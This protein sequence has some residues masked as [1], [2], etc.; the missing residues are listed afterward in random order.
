MRMGAVGALVGAGFTL[1]LPAPRASAAAANWVLLSEATPPPVSGSNLTYDPVT[2]DVVY[3]G[4][5]GGSDGE[6]WLFNGSSWSQQTTAA[7]PP[8]LYEPSIAYDA[9]T[10]YVVLYGGYNGA[11]NDDQTWL[12]DGTNWTL[13]N[14]PAGPPPLAGASLAYDPSLGELVMYGGGNDDYSPTSETW[15]YNGTTW[16]EQFPVTSPPPADDCGFAY[17]P[18][19]GQM[20]LFG[21]G[22]TIT[23]SYTTWTYDGTN[24]TELS[25]ATTPN[26]PRTNAVFTWDPALNEFILFGGYTLVNSDDVSIGDTWAFDGNNWT[27]LSPAT[28]PPSRY[29]SALVYDPLLG[30]LV[31]FGG[32]NL[33]NGNLSNLNDTWTYGAPD[34]QSI[35]FTSTEPSD[36]TIATSPYTPTATASSSLPVTI[37]LDPSST[38]CSLSSGVVTFNSVGTCVLDANQSGDL[39]WSAAVQVQQTIVIHQESQTIDFSTTPP[40]A[41]VTGGTPYTP[42]ATASSGLPVTIT[43]DS[44]S[45][46]CTISDGVVSFPALGTCVID[47]NQA[48]DANYPAASEVQQVIPIVKEYQAISFSSTPPEDG[49]VGD[50]YTPTATATSGLAVTITLDSS[51]SGCSLSGGVVTFTTN[52]DSCEIDANQGGDGHWTAASQAQQD[53]PVGPQAQAI[54]FTSPAPTDAAVAGSTYTPKASATSGLTV[55][56]SL[57]SKSS[58]CSLTD[59]VVSFTKVGTCRIDGNQAGNGVYEPA[60][61]AQQSFAIGRGTQTLSFTS[62]AP[63]TR[64]IGGAAYKPYAKSSAGLGTTI[65]LDASSS[66]CALA[67]GIVTF[68]AVGT[69]VIDANQAGNTEYLPGLE[70]QQRIPVTANNQTSS[71][72]STPPSPGYVDDATYTPTATAT[73]G[74][75][76]FFTLAPSS[77]GCRVLSGVV[78]FTA[79]GTCVIDARQPGDAQ[80]NP[81]PLVAQS[82]SVVSYELD[83]PTA[84]ASTG[85]DVFVANT[86]G[87]SVTMINASTG[88]LVKVLSGGSYGFAEPVAISASGSDVWVVNEGGASVTELNAT[89]GAFVRLISNFSS[90]IFDNPVAIS[91]DGKHVWVADELGNDVVELS[92]A[93]GNVVTTLTTPIYPFNSP[94][95]ISS[96][97]THVWVVNASY[98]VIELSAHT[99]GYVATLSVA[100]YGF[101]SDNAV[102]SDGARVWVTNT[103]TNT[104]TIINALTGGFVRTVSASSGDFNQPGALWSD[105]THVWVVDNGNNTASELNA[106]T[107]GLVTHIPYTNYDFSQAASIYSDG[108]HVWV[109]NSKGDSVTEMS[110][111]D[112]A[113]VTIIKG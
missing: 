39:Q 49:T 112:G 31:M 56:L 99:G 89:T 92:A 29:E 94:D 21:P 10:G 80:Y 106:S 67:S 40:R 107:G 75:P 51:S 5:V 55:T 44:T 101:A 2:Q 41:E 88:A 45:T 4:D 20:V 52:G 14:T 50:H 6:T 74:L 8:P 93:T 42:G 48:G 72:T 63:K 27:Q 83:E 34:A 109:A 71:F 54:S 95:A 18:N 90:T 85:T 64:E 26:P 66:G 86:K 81:A 17:D 15:T 59:G 58:G 103:G 113:L 97:G 7:S 33:V 43:L 36:T 96:D 69:C 46:G 23:G 111:S 87:N 104:V 32:N 22:A 102:S 24:W 60:A 47:A 82:I 100:D 53:I 30:Q 77:K 98:T 65:S 61:Q 84:I 28:V 68:T 9:A 105:G 91:S 19:T 1:A 35:S 76:V 62:G 3:L 79:A 12:Y 108:T 16:T 37:T 11:P 13:Q 70:V 38:G 73:S 78:Q 25:P 110:A 57:D